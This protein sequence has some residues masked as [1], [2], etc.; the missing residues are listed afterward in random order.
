MSARSDAVKIPISAISTRSDYRRDSLPIL[1]GFVPPPRKRRNTVAKA[2]NSL[3]DVPEDEVLSLSPRSSVVSLEWNSEYDDADITLNNIP[4]SDG[5]NL[6]TT[7]QSTQFSVSVSDI[8]D[9]IMAINED[10][11]DDLAKHKN[12]IE[13]LG[14]VF[15]DDYAEIDVDDLASETL[16]KKINAAERL[17]DSLR[18]SMNFLKS[19]DAA[20]YA[21]VA[22]ETKKLKKDV[23]TFIRA[24]EKRLGTLQN[25]QIQLGTQRSAPTVQM[26]S[27]IQKFKKLRVQNNFQAFSDKLDAYDMDVKELSSRSVESDIEFCQLEEES[28][29]KLKQVG[30]AIKEAAAMQDEALSVNL[31]D[32]AVK[33]DVQITSIKKSM[34]VLENYLFDS[35]SKLG[36]IGSS[37]N[38]KNLNLEL[39]KFSGKP[40]GLDFFTFKKRFEEYC[41]LERLSS[42]K[43]VHVLKVDCIENESLRLSLSRY[44]TVDEVFDFLEKHYGNAE[45]LLWEKREE[46]LKCGKFPWFERGKGNAHPTK[47][48]DWLLNMESKLVELKDLAE[49]H[50]IENCLYYSDVIY[51]IEGFLPGTLV[52]DFMEELAKSPGKQTGEDLY[53]FFIK[54]LNTLI[55]RYTAKVNHYAASSQQESHDKSGEKDNKDHKASNS[56]TTLHMNHQQGKKNDKSKSYKGKPF[57]N[58]TNQGQG[59]ASSQA[60]TPKLLD[61]PIKCGS[62]HT[63]L[64]YCEKFQ[65]LRD[66]KKRLGLC[67]HNKICMRCLRLDSDVDLDNRQDWWNAHDVNCQTDFACTADQC[68]NRRKQSQVHMLVCC[69]HYKSNKPKEDDFIQSLDQQQLGQDVKFFTL[70]YHS[71]PEDIPT[72]SSKDALPDVKDPPIFLVHNITVE[73]KKLLV[74]YDSGAAA[75][76]ISSRGYKY[77]DCVNVRPGPTFI[78]VANAEVVKCD[79]GDERFLLP[80]ETGEKATMTALKMEAITTTFPEWEIARA[81]PDVVDHLKENDL[82]V[83]LPS[84]PKAI[85]GTPVDVLIGFKYRQYFPKELFSLPCGLG[86]YRARLK[87]SDSNQA[88]L[89]GPHKAWKTAFDQSSSMSAMMFLTMEARVLLFQS[90]S[91]TNMMMFSSQ[92]DKKC[93]EDVDV[94]AEVEDDIEEE[95][96]CVFALKTRLHVLGSK[97]QNIKSVSSDMMKVD[98]IGSEVSYRCGKCR[99]CMDCKKGEILEETSLAEEAEQ[100]MIQ[101]GIRLDLESCKVFSSLPFIKNPA[102]NLTPNKHIAYKVF[103][104]QKKLCRANPEMKDDLIKAH[105]KLVDNGFVHKVRDL[106]PETVE[107]MKTFPGSDYVIPW[108][109]VYKAGSLSTPCRLVFD[110]SS[111]TPRAESLN[112]TL[113]TGKNILGSLYQILLRFKSKPVGVCCDVKM[114]YNGVNL[115]EEYFKYHKYLWQDDLDDNNPIEEWVVGTAIY[116]E[117]PAGNMTISA[118]KALAEHVKD[119]HPQHQLGADSL[120]NNSYVD[121]IVQAA[122]DDDQAEKIADDIT[123]TLGKGSMSVKAFAFS[124]KSPPEEV[125]A[126]GKTV[127]VL[128]Y[129]W[130]PE[131]DLMSLDSKEI[132]L[133]KTKRG[134]PPKPIRGNY[135]DALKIS[136]TKRTLTRVVA[137][138]FDPIGIFVPV[139]S[140]LKLD[141]HEIVNLNLDWDD[142]IPDTF[143]DKWT[144]NLV[145]IKDLRLLRFRRAV[146]PDDAKEPT[147]ELIVSCDASENIAVAVVHARF[148]KKDGTFSCQ[149]LTAKSKLVT[150]STIPR[151]ELK[152]AR[153]GAAL[154]F[155]AKSNLNASK[156]KFV[157]DSTI[158]L[159]WI[160]QDSRPLQTFV[161]NA[162]IEVRR[163]SEQSDWFHI[164]GEL[165]VADI[166]TR[167]IAVDEVGVDSAW[168]NGTDWMNAAENDMPVKGFAEIKL[169]HDEKNLAAEEVKGLKVA[170][171]HTMQEFQEESHVEK[172][173]LRYELSDYI[174]DPAKMKWQKLVRCKAAVNRFVE[175]LKKK[176]KGEI[177]EQGDANDKAVKFE[178]PEL[179]EAEKYFW[180]KG[181]KEVEEFAQ[182]KLYKDHSV[183]VNDVLHYT[184]RIIEGQLVEDPEGLFPDLQ[185]LSYVKPIL[186]RYSPLS[187]RV[188]IQAHE[189]ISH[190]SAAATLQKSR[191][192]A[193]ILQGESLAAEITERC[194]RCIRSRADK[195]QVEMGKIH[196]NRLAIASPF[197]YSQCD[198]FG[199]LTAICEHNHRSTVKVYGLVFKCTSSLAVSVHCMQSYS[200]DS[201]LSAFVRFSS[202]H[203]YPK[204]LFIDEGSQLVKGCK[205]M[206][207]ALSDFLKP[208]ETRYETGI[209]FETSDVG[210]H[211]STGMVER[212]IREVKRLFSTM[213]TGLRIDVLMYET[214]FLH[215]SS[216]LN[217]MPISLGPGFK[218]YHS[219]DLLTPN[220][221]IMGRNNSRAPVGHAE[222][223]KP[224][225]LLE[226]MDRVKKAWWDVW[227]TERIAEFIP[228]NKKWNKTTYQPKVGDICLFLRQGDDNSFGPS[229]WRIG[230]VKEVLV[231]KDDLARHVI[232]EYKNAN[233]RVFRETKR[234][235]RTIAILH[236]EDDIWTYE[237]LAEARS[238]ASSIKPP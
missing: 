200:T 146:I 38:N 197:Y 6:S 71:Q 185:P 15:Q 214:A 165:N 63:H 222:L 159:H 79:G 213:Y 67:T 78:T 140:G 93:E 194:P 10:G 127:G 124:K 111:R 212:S 21:T 229:V 34:E 116:G 96:L 227:K 162:V 66:F 145:R 32:E 225:R 104:S 131:D 219:L 22:D 4:S 189:G 29:H 44:E 41:S 216:E 168:Q 46:L 114:A 86:V 119:N 31:E 228:G 25:A 150:T 161:R 147:P 157:T 18:S 61:C 50:E 117:R 120:D 181:T 16:S 54:F 57:K 154:G 3:T 49:M 202:L 82:D 13:Q 81:W 207:I 26:D 171:I 193:Y 233:E 137:S 105:N 42:A 138:V 136:F 186:D 167:K 199:P 128:G 130:Y 77:L 88:V 72:D 191:E 205:E 217:N 12:N 80:L 87:C 166:G 125:S 76:A 60:E 95:P 11:M 98:K 55:S 91:L 148:Q 144:G 226:Q 237:L 2:S 192:V 85:G 142:D 68:K 126:D 47:Q 160:N 196:S 89:G 175:N 215:I 164:P 211:Y 9:I 69:Y 187:Y 183:K 20:Y 24:A 59:T 224:S 43:Q 141:L 64:F 8:D 218:G 75:S 163:L 112:S 198:I 101:D 106:N 210:A 51:K 169:S 177:A 174:V 17:K 209:E 115:E 238:R 153:M 35:K 206:K 58:Q 108:R 14:E 121:D 236:K 37:H 231:S 195:L 52:D 118:F 62:K 5:R 182:K 84:A 170:E 53:L 56:R 208:L 1:T 203:G 143:L 40:S 180:L 74:F 70:I 176:V 102:E 220:R 188:M 190:R 30:D 7:T 45:K 184:G 27:T 234:S 99:I 19:N 155:I 129:N 110:A 134:K 113:A 135:K 179:K 48:R 172:I 149:I 28:K 36:L 223:D 230:I 100:K 73:G 139:T 123:F 92:E 94:E 83:D 107:K 235:V 23:L 132:Y 109:S 65:R 103:E 173:A 156:V 97:F 178:E 221:L 33:L 158:V 122:D 90:K 232:I 201:F 152:S 133:D 151:A 39:P 204:K